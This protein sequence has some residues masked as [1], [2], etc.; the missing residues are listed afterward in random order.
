LSVPPIRTPRLELI[1]ATV[2]I[3]RAEIHDRARFA[4]ALRVPGPEVWPPPLNDDESMQWLLGTLE[5][6]PGAVGWAAWYVVLREE[7]A[8]AGRT[9][10]TAPTA[11]ALIGNAGFFGPPGADGGVEM[12]Y[13]ILE[14]HQGRG[15]A[16]E[17]LR[18][19]ISWAFE[20][21]GV[22]RV[23]ARTFPDNPRSIRVLEKCGLR[24]FEPGRGDGSI[25]F[26]LPRDNPV[27]GARGLP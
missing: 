1:P 2:E 8:S 22:R 3:A 6:D 27:G 13:S 12:G 5:R 26:E 10:G 19:L 14:A 7:S 16:T 17:A 21:S 4:A 11:R 15:Y 9:A 24:P 20:H 18:A 25:G 23:F